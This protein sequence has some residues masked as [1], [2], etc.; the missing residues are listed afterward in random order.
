VR[1]LQSQQALPVLGKD[2]TL[3]SALARKLRMEPRHSVAILN[4][5]PGYLESLAPAPA[6]VRTELGP[7]NAFEVVQLF[8][9]GVDELKGLG[10]AAIRAVKGGGIL[11]ITYS[12]GG[13]TPLH[14]RWDHLD[15]SQ[16][17]RREEKVSTRS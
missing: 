15:V 11:W 7:P 17:D 2:K 16:A 6:D 9:S 14:R 3:L 10:P 4:A 12:K 8:V 13:R 1:R 5:P